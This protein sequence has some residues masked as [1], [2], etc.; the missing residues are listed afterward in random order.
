MPQ[1]RLPPGIKSRKEQIDEAVRKA[2]AG[3]ERL[4]KGDPRFETEDMPNV[5]KDWEK[6]VKA[7]PLPSQKDWPKKPE[8]MTKTEWALQVLNKGRKNK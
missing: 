4:A 1:K 8:H 7:N 6:W 5:P 3:S 2:L